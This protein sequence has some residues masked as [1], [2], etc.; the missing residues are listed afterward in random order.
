MLFAHDPM[1]QKF[2][3]G[4]G[5]CLFSGFC[6]GLIFML[7]LVTRLGRS[8]MVQESVTQLVGVWQIIRIL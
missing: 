6:L 5:K 1:N 4:L 7:L 8:G 3:L 2:G